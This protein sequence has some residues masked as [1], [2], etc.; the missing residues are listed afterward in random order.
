MADD[1]YSHRTTQSEKDESF[2]V[3]RMLGVRNHPRIL[4]EKGSSSLLERDAMLASIGRIL[5]LIPLESQGIHVI[6]CTD[7]V[8]YGR[9][10]SE[11]ASS[12]W[13]GVPTH[14]FLGVHHLTSW[15]T[16]QRIALRADAADC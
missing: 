8:V 1:E 9:V 12:I 4:V 5:P 16:L 11:N 6:Q 3:I 10:T 2:L 13:A 7:T 15:R 14:A